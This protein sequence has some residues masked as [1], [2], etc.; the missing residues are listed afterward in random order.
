MSSKSI[1]II[2]I[3]PG[4]RN[5]GW[6]VIEA[7]GSRLSFVACGTLHSDAGAPLAERLVVQVTDAHGNPVEGH[8]ISWFSSAGM[9]EVRDFSNTTDAS[10]KADAEA[11]KIYGDAYGSDAEFYA[12][13]RTLESYRNLGDNATLMLDADSEFFRYLNSTRKR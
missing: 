6:G 12:F 4:L 2:G 5:T 8:R 3:D 10:G 1:R 7:E 13:F 11:T 9:G